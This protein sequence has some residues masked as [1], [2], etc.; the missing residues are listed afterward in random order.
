MVLNGKADATLLD[1]YC[2]ER[3]PAA[4]ENI[5]VS[6]RTTRFLRPPTTAERSFRGAVVELARKHDFARSLVNT[7]RMTQPN[8]YRRSKLNVGRGGGQPVPNCSVTLPDGRPGDLAQLLRWANGNFIAIV[9]DP[10]ERH[11][12]LEVRYPVRVLAAGKL[13][14]GFPALAAAT[15]AGDAAAI[16]VRPDGYCAGCL[17]SGEVDTLEHA[18][19]ALSCR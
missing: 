16:I 11:R 12:A 17:D 19:R 18:L 4:L 6:D 7:G 2:E 1:T 15:G 9:R 5:R 13:G 8:V 10:G 3:R 14:A